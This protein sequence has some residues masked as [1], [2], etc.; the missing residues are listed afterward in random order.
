MTDGLVAPDSL[1][2]LLRSLTLAGALL[3]VGAVPVCGLVA[4][5]L[6]GRD[7]TETPA[8]RRLRRL[9][10]AACV[11]LAAAA[12]LTL[13]DLVGAV[14]ALEAGTTTS[15]AAAQVLG[16][17]LGSWTAARVVV[18]VACL[19]LVPWALVEGSRTAWWAWGG[20]AGLLVLTLPMT[21]HPATHGPVAVA[22]DAVHLLSGAVWLTGVVA[23]AFVVP[24]ALRSGRSD[25]RRDTLLHAAGSFSR[26]AVVAVLVALATGIAQAA[27]VGVTPATAAGSTWG[28]A[29][30][31]KVWLFAAVVAAGL[32]NHRFLLARLEAARSRSRIQA[33]STALLSVVSLEVVL[34]VAMVAAAALLVSVPQP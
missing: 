17:S 14:R 30:T 4:P 6:R 16:S 34:G 8:L 29:A 7:G 19:V 2:L 11:V 20:L 3:V 18:A 15:S 13:A 1:G 9:L 22:V 21:S 5:R 27:V 10:Q 28:A 23:L 25:D 33:G 32:L 31:A 24:L 12:L 26:I